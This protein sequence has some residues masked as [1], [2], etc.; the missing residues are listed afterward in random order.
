VSA[1]RSAF[2]LLLAV[3]VIAVG[4]GLAA[5][6]P[7][8][9]G[10]PTAEIPTE[11]PTTAP[12]TTQAPP[13]ASPTFQAKLGVRVTAADLD[14]GPAYWNGNGAGDFD[15]AVVNTGNVQEAIGG[16]YAMPAG[17]TG[18]GSSGTGGCTTSGATFACSLSPGATGRVTVRATVASD[19][20]RGGKLLT[21]TATAK[22]QGGPSHSD[23]FSV[24][25]PPGPPTPGISLTA[26]KLALGPASTPPQPDGGDLTVKLGNTGSTTATG[27]V[28]IVTPAGVDLVGFP[29]ICKS[30]RKVA[31]DRDRC[32]V[33]SVTAGTV[34]SGAFR[35][36]ISP[37]ARAAA[38]LTGA[39]YGYLAGQTSVEVLANYQIIVSTTVLASEPTPSASARAEPARPAET[40]PKPVL[41]NK[42]TSMLPFTIAALVLLGAA[43][44]IFFVRRRKPPVVEVPAKQL[45]PVLN[46]PKKLP[47]GPVAGPAAHWD[48]EA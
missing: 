19:A 15:I 46:L 18:T 40:T 38:P 21:G 14:L 11:Q 26:S 43:G 6:D 25:F 33:G 17:V 23:G 24:L 5:A 4:P 1:L 16:T 12:P 34:L 9:T 22:V 27:A 39:V 30:H 28:E 10:S 7:D 35:L 45:E 20:W 36:A 42:K 44:A 32:E 41:R 48:D 2:A 29:A 13:P 3:A 47:T 37:E 8:P 31:A